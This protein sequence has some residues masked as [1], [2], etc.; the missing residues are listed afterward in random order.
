MK[1]SELRFH[2]YHLILYA[3][4]AQWLK[5]QLCKYEQDN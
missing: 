1:L 4:S 2:I 3:K 5:E